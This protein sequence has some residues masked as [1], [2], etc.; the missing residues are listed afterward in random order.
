MGV[1]FLREA[2]KRLSSLVARWIMACLEARTKAAVAYLED[3]Y[4]VSWSASNG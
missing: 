4:P 1:L 3:G 2:R